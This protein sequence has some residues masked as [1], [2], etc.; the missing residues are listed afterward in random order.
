[1]QLKII[2]RVMQFLLLFILLI[3][4]VSVFAQ[5]KSE[6]THPEVISFKGY[7]TDK[8]GEMLSDAEYDLTFSIYK[9]AVAGIDLWSEIHKNVAVKNGEFKV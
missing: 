1:M 6:I 2:E 7:L 5:E 8:A 3:S 9:K 4:T